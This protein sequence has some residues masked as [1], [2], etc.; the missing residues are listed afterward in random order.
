[1][2]RSGFLIFVCLLAVS[3]SACARMQARPAVP[4][5][6]SVPPP[7]PRVPIPYTIPEPEEV[8]LPEP[9]PPAPPVA[10]VKPRPE[11]PRTAVTTPPPT[12]AP[13]EAPAPVLQTTANVSAIQQKAN[14]LLS[15]AQQNLDRVNYRDLSV[16]A[17]AQYDRATGFIKGAH[18]ALQTRNFNYAQQLAEKAATLARELLKG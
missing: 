14:G 1:V 9:P 5:A 13:A 16:H 10:P 3:G 11:T 8:L 4:V 15:E 7:P 2:A 18:S 12:A 6:L 17:K